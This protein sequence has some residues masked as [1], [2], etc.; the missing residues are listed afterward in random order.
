MQTVFD[1]T[2]V[3]NTFQK[4]E[5][6]AWKKKRNSLFL[7]WENDFAHRTDVSWAIWF[8]DLQFS[9]GGH[10]L[11]GEVPECRF[12]WLDG[13]LK[14]LEVKTHSTQYTYWCEEHCS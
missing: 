2:L 1:S 6:M 5:A 3:C 11:A 12:G 4:Y 13:I 10:N 8:C 14:H 9:E 7:C